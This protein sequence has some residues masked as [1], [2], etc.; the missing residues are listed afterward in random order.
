MSNQARASIWGGGAT[1]NAAW[2]GRRTDS[3]TDNRS[4]SAEIDFIGAGIMG[5]E[6]GSQ[7][8]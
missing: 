7:K 5:N 4:R 6:M 3:R 8:L 1:G 2:T